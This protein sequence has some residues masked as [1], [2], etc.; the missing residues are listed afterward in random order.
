M[1]LY[2]LLFLAMLLLAGCTGDKDSSTPSSPE[3][4]QRLDQLED[5]VAEARVQVMDRQRAVGFWRTTCV[6]VGVLGLLVGILAGTKA[7]EAGRR[8]RTAPTPTSAAVEEPCD[9]L[10]Y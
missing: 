10:G 9:D 4:Q 2:P 7:T 8:P 1:H 5:A 6:V 3:S